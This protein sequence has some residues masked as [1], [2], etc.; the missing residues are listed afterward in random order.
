M[1]ERGGTK[2]WVSLG[3]KLMRA[4]MG[5]IGVRLHL[6]VIFKLKLQTASRMS[7]NLDTSP[8]LASK[9]SPE[10]NSGNISIL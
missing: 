8:K 1:D 7:A 2:R 6:S 3:I 4:V 5:R 10:R 9:V